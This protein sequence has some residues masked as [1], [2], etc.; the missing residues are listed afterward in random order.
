VNTELATVN[1]LNGRLVGAQQDHIA[2]ANVLTDKSGDVGYVLAVRRDGLEY[3][4]WAYGPNEAR[5]GVNVY[6]G[7]YF[8]VRTFGGAY[9]AFTDAHRN[10]TARAHVP[11]DPAD[12]LKTRRTESEPVRESYYSGEQY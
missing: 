7:H 5:T 3:V 6:W 4:T 9:E 2:V 10:L 12:T 1:Q 11:L 8:P